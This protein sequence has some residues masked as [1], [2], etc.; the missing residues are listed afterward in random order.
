LNNDDPLEIAETLSTA[1]C[2]VTATNTNTPIFEG[3]SMLPSG[4][5]INGIGSYTPEMQ[6]VPVRVVDRC[7]ILIDTPEARDVGDLKNIAP[8]RPVTFLGDAL[9]DPEH[10]LTHHREKAPMLDF[11][12]YKAVGT[13]IQDIVTADMVVKRARELGVGTNIDMGE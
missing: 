12:F 3:S 11:S 9:Q 4:C 2:I 8:Q 5:H 13:A 7:N 10:W 1:D 6:E